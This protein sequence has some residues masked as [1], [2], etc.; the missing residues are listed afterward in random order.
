MDLPDRQVPGQ[1]IG[2]EVDLG[3]QALGILRDDLGLAHDPRVAAAE[4]A[5]LAAE[6]D[7]EVERDR[8]PGRDRAEPAAVVFAADRFAEI[9]RRRVARVARQSPL[10][11]AMDR[12]GHGENYAPGF[13]PAV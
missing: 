12:V 3:H 11:M 2:D 6:G 4:P 9:R 7:V 10:E 13:R 1:R 8:R 5:Q